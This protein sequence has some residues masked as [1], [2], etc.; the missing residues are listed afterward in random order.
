VVIVSNNFLDKICGLFPPKLIY[1]ILNLFFFLKKA[2]LLS[3]LNNPNFFDCQNNDVGTPR[4]NNGYPLSPS[5]IDE[6]TRERNSLRE[7][8]AQMENNYAY[9]FKRYK[10][11]R[12]SCVLLKMFGFIF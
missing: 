7:D 4:N 9:L 10:K 8:M 5:Q 3:R 2:Q 6:L 1:L 11:L 12:E